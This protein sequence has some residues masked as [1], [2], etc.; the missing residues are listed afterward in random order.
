[1]ILAAL[2]VTFHTAEQN[3]VEDVLRNL[4]PGHVL[5]AKGATLEIFN[6]KATP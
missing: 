6:I 1:M 4:K 3:W 2:F 5:I